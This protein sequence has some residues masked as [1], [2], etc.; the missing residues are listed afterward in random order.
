LVEKPIYQKLNTIADWIIRLILINIMVVIT[1]LPIVT[2]YVAFSSGYNCFAD[3]LKKDEVGVIKSFINHLKTH[4][5]K[6][7][8]L[9]ILFL[10]FI[11]IFYYN[12]TYYEKLLLHD[13]QTFYQIGYFVSLS[14]IIISFVIF[15]QSFAVSYVYINL[16]LIKLLKLSLLVSGKYFLF[17]IVLL[18]TYF[19]PYWLFLG[20][21]TFVISVF[22]GF[23]I[24]LLINAFITKRVVTY[25]ESLVIANG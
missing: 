19:I 3:V 13:S 16:P 24:P 12:M 7:L 25:L 5:V 21:Y 10:L 8:I 15:L 6:K 14:L 18:S 23:S 20:T 2:F 1:A 4:F 17:S 22:V 9:G 11:L